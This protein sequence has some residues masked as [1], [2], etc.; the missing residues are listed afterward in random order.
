[1]HTHAHAHTR[2]HTHAHAPTRTH[3]HAHART[4][5]HAQ[6]I[7]RDVRQLYEDKLLLRTQLEA[8]KQET[9]LAEETVVNYRRGMVDLLD[10]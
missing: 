2:T 8:A 1:M 3:T 5:T 4:C 9:K 10:V 6:A 7:K